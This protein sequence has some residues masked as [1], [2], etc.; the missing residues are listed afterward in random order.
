MTQRVETELTVR[1]WACAAL[2][3]LAPFVALVARRPEPA[4]IALPLALLAAFELGAGRPRRPRLVASL[5]TERTVEDVAVELRFEIHGPGNVARVQLALPAGI[6]IDSVEGARRIDD[7]WL[8]VR[9]SRGRAEVSVALRPQRWG[10][11]MVGVRQVVFE[12]MI[13]MRRVT[14][15]GTELDQL[16]V[17][18]ATETLRSLVDPHDTS[19]ATGDLVSRHWGSGTELADTRA[20]ANG[21][22]PRSINWRA[23]L[24]SE[25]LWVTERQAERAGDVV[26][27]I[28]P[29]ASSSDVG[30][31]TRQVISL[32][33]SLIKAFGG[34]RH[35]LGMIDLSGQVSWFG[36]STGAVHRQK[37]LEA[38]LAS[39]L[40]IAPIWMA[41]DR[42][43][44][45]VVHRPTMVVFISTLSGPEVAGRAAMLASGGIDVTVVA[46][47]PLARLNRPPDDTRDMARRVWTLDRERNLDRLRSHGVAVAEWEPGRT[48]D[49]LM[50]ELNRWRSRRRGARV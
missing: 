11:Y 13:P 31:A 42:V 36:L 17:L 24:R 15:S 9:L 39:Q 34:E 25:E 22:S 28:D 30:F 35:R 19:L 4:I 16:S 47:D 10:G 18:P 2:A 5:G 43:L 32:A 49:E 27:V 46:I 21:D 23:T 50:E 48:L 3:V 40:N 33:A 45:R 8:S 38:T 7:E 12:Q 41:V 37:L 14:M 44:N 29:I 20:F 6:A 26:L 1:G